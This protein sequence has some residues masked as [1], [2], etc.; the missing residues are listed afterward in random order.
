PFTQ[1]YVRPQL[2]TPA[3]T[4]IPDTGTVEQTQTPLLDDRPIEIA[5]GVSGVRKDGDS[6]PAVDTPVQAFATLGDR[7]YVGGKFD[8]VRDSASGDLVDQNYLAAFDRATGAWIPSFAPQLDG[9]VWDLTIADGRLIVAGQFTNVDGAERTAGLAALDPVT[10][11]VDPDWN[12]SLTLSGSTERPYVRAIDVENGWLYVGG[13]FTSIGHRFSD[14]TTIDR[15]TGRMARLRLTD[16]FPDNQFLPDVD[17]TVYDVDAANGRVHIVGDFDGVNRATNGVGPFN[18]ATNNDKGVSTVDAVS[19]EVIAAYLPAEYSTSRVSRQYQQAVLA[20]GGQVY[21]GGSEH[22]VHVYSDVD[23]SLQE[24]WV[25]SGNGGDTQAFASIDGIVYQGSHANTWI[26]T[27]AT[28]WPGLADY[29]RVD[30]Y[31]WVGAFDVASQTY[32]KNWVPSLATRFNEGTWALHADVD[33]CLWFGGDFQGGP[34][35][36]G[37]RQYL[38][39]FGKFCQRDIV[40]PTV[41]TGA[42]ASVVPGDGGI[43]ID[44]VA[45]SDDRPGFIGYEILR[46]DRVV[47]P[48]VYGQTYVDPAGSVDD[49]YFVRAVD[50]AGNRSASTAVL[51]PGDNLAPS[52]PQG[53]TAEVDGQV[54]TLSWEPSTDDVGIERYEILRNGA[55]LVDVAGDT[56]TVEL[57]TLGAGAHWLQVVAVDAAGNE[58]FK[59]PPV[60]VD[61]DGPDTQRPTQPGS[62][63]AVVEDDLTITF[64]WSASSDDTGVTSYVV[65]RNLDEV[66]TVDGTTTTVNVDLGL[67]THFLQVEAVDAAGN[68]SFRTAPVRVD[69]ADASVDTTRPSTPA[70]LTA[71]EGP[72]G[73]V[74]VSWTAST[75]DVGVDRYVVLRNLAVV[76]EV[77]GATTSASIPDL[78]AGDHFMQVQA[79]DAAG[80]ESFRTPPVRITLSAG[81][82]TAPTTP[83]DLSAVDGGDGSIDVTWTASTDA[84][85]VDRY[86]VLRNGVQ[87]AEV[88]GD[89]TVADLVGLGAG[90]HYIQVRAFDAAGNA[91]FKTP[92]VLVTLTGGPD[93]TPPSFARDL[94]AVVEADG[95]VTVSWT[96]AT[97][98]VALAGHRVLRNLA[99]VATVPVPDMTVNLDLGPGTHYVQ[100][101]SF[102]AAGNES[103]RTAPVVVTL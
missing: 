80:N 25:T 21:E 98:D 73:V 14:G 89:V 83:Q 39:G 82:V 32:L 37:Q 7:V 9:T 6:E 1:V 38:E 16:G 3:S 43:R 69:V 81:D 4:P 87:V 65:R 57:D 17:G 72:G 12:A 48:L 90:D 18:D 86:I 55:D 92:P 13:N 40:A 19:G 71:V 88:A 27:G 29:E 66:T 59:T 101:V 11:E 58:S 5:G 85:G 67:G 94:A 33:G 46:D 31:D 2:V 102:D 36:N 15:N 77:D 10:G 42:A 60:R 70:D 75:D 24:R 8:D 45:S 91:S 49:R 51:V 97:D 28:T 103:G 79:I 22:N 20:I 93:V 23:Y 100:V 64:S 50:P 56:T 44:W 35:V 74:D 78:G 99:E 52:T 53:L 34:F 68:T 61:L 26:Y 30:V 84:V 95:T 54:V 76:A 63:D 41:P 62:P 96:S 47:S